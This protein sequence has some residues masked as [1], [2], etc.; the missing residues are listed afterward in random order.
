VIHREQK[1]ERYLRDPLPV[2]LGGLAADLARIASS[3]RF[4]AAAASV[5]Q[6]LEE[7]QYF[8]EWTAAEAE[9]E[10]AA[11]L[12]DIQLMIA[13]WRKAWP[14]A[15]QSQAQRTLL[16]VQAKKWSDQVLDYSGLLAM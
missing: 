3:A 13:I 5:E 12:V 16:S 14:D 8:I 2:R 15:Q 1:K 11:E 10:I 9:P 4:P 6:M 7:S